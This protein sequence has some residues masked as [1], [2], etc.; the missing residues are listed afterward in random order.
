VP[1]IDATNMRAAI[2]SRSPGYIASTGACAAGGARALR[3]GADCDA[4]LSPR[5]AL[6]VMPGGG[7]E[8]LGGRR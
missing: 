8:G 6:A 3:A 1:R 4:F 2:P 5:D 7:V